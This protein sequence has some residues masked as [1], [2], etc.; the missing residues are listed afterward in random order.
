MIQHVTFC[1]WLLTLTIMF[2]RFIEVVEHISI[3]F[4]F[5]AE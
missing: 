4:L 1:V 2:L 5:M 3:T